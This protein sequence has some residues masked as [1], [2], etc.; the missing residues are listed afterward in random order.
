MG[1]YIGVPLFCGAKIEVVGLKG[2]R[3]A[4]TVKGFSAMNFGK[5]HA[6]GSRVQGS[7]ACFNY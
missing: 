6:L 1:V 4:L 3:A 5:E 2:L 7:G